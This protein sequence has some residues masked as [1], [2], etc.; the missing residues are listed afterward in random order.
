MRTLAFRKSAPSEKEES[1]ACDRLVTIVG[2]E[3]VRF[4]QPRASMQS[5]GIPDRLYRIKDTAFFWEAKR[6]NG[7][8][9]KEQD[10]FLSAE[11]RCN[12]LAGAGTFD[13]LRPITAAIVGGN[14]PLAE[15][16]LTQSVIA[17]RARG[18]R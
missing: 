18:Y 3:I 10:A 11:R 16:L 9:T 2:G 1:L 5:E 15:R 8:L 13:D 6:A 14:V 4:S 12:R 7:R 17:L